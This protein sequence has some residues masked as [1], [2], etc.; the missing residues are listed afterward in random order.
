MTVFVPH[1]AM[2]GGTLIAL[3]AHDIVMDQN[4]I[5]GPVDPQLGEYP[6]VSILRAVTQKDVNEVDDESLILADVAG[7][8]LQQ[9]KCR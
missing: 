8:A 6:A 2:S 5:L 1:Y 4:A 9:V 3:A 7:K